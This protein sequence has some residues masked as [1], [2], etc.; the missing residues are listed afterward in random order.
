MLQNALDILRKE[1]KE[2]L[3]CLSGSEEAQKAWL[4]AGGEAVPKRF[5]H[6]RRSINLWSY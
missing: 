1:G 5:A 3:V 2:I 6:L 4:A